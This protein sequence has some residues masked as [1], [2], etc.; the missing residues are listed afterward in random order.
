MNWKKIPAAALSVLMLAGTAG[1]GASKAPEY[2]WSNVAIGGGG[3]VTGMVYS[4]AEENLVYAR[5]DIGGAYRWTESEQRWVAITDHLGSENWNLIGIESIA[6]DPVEPGRVYAMGGTYMG[7]RGA[8]FASEDYGVHWTQVDMPFDCGANNSGRGT[9]ERLMVNPQK[10]STVY[11]G[12][13]ND[14]LYRTDDY[15]QTWAKVESFPTKGNYSQ[16]AISMG[17]M[18]IE[19]NPVNNDVYAGVAETNGVCIYRSSDDGATWEALPANEPGMYPLQAD[20]DDKGNLYLAYSDNCG[21]NLSPQHG[22]VYK[23]DGSGFIDITPDL[24][25]GRYGGFGAVSVDKQNPD[26]LVVCTLGFWADNGDNIYRSTDGGE[27][28]QGLFNVNTGEKNY[29]MDVSRAQWLN[30][31]R[32]EAKTGWWTS[33]ININPFNSDEV[34]YGTGATI[35]TAQN[36][37]DLGTGTPVTIAFDAYGLEETAVFQMVSPEYGKDEPQLYSIMGDLTGFSHLDVTAG[38]D[39]DHF[40]GSHSGSAP[41]SLDAAFKA[42]VSAAYTVEDKNHPIWYTN[43]GG[44]TWQSLDA[45]E[46]VE[47]GRVTLSADGSILIWVPANVGNS[48]IYQYDFNAQGWYYVNGLGYGAKIAA[49]RVNPSKFY[50]AYNGSFYSSAD[51][52]ATFTNTGAVIAEGCDVYTVVGREDNVWLCNGSLVMYS[53][54]GGKTFTMIKDINFKAIGFGAPEKEGQ[55]PAIYAMGSAGEQGDGI[56]RSTDKGKTWQRINDDLHLFGNLTPSITGD[57]RVFGRVYFATNG[58][59]IVM[60]DP[61][62]E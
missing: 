39:N 31:G 24:D 56:Y 54:D 36:M 32:E 21:P 46:K 58:R 18:W 61:A 34:M 51:G 11:M 50:A 9:G 19:F 43:D 2:K 49:D 5:T 6:A 12:T 57:S 38:P 37:T 25:D 7:T 16:E 47:G 14:G 20:F 30:W 35:Y 48:N 4:E 52:G 10:N 33:D 62:A 27:T 22:A 28:W 15:G 26:T 59:G 8:V 13:R 53:E 42:P 29:V 3:Y 45:P 41:V 55:Y 60:G 40:M 1:C 23:Y 44:S 17:V